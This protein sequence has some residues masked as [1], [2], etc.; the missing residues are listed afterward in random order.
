MWNSNF[1]PALGLL[2]KLMEMIWPLRSM[3]FQTEDLRCVPPARCCG[4]FLSSSIKWTAW[5]RPRSRPVSPQEV[6][7]WRVEERLGHG[8]ASWAAPEHPAGWTAGGCKCRSV[9][10]LTW[11][12]GQYTI[13]LWVQS[14]TLMKKWGFLTKYLFLMRSSS[15]WLSSGKEL[16][17]CRGAEFWRKAIL[18]S[19]LP[20]QRKGK[21]PLEISFIFYC[22]V[23]EYHTLS[24]WKHQTIFSHF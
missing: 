21:S 16:G 5:P 15:S 10:R 19:Q 2:Y 22:C 11:S 6:M 4:F 9:G 23:T 20:F 14:W 1:T 8:L 13:F 3:W 7:G 24:C 18:G 12:L 17:T